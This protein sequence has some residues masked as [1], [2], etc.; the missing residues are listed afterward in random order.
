MRRTFKTLIWWRAPRKCWYKLL[1]DASE[2]SVKL[3]KGSNKRTSVCSWLDLV[4][5]HQR[6][7]RGMMVWRRTPKRRTRTVTSKSDEEHPHCGRRS[8]NM[9]RWQRILL[10]PWKG[11]LDGGCLPL[12]DLEV[13]GHFLLRIWI[14]ALLRFLLLSAVVY[15]QGPMTNIYK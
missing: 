8:W 10:L 5:W 6:S 15:S 11:S 3:P 9:S 13:Q 2:N 7:R 4:K 12:L 14:G 1:I